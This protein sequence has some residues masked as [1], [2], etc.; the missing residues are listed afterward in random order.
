MAEVIK[1]GFIVDPEILALV[2]KDPVAAMSLDSDAFVELITRAI[3][4]KADVVSS[5]PTEQGRAEI[6]NYGHTF[7]HAIQTGAGSR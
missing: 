7:A 6:R 3:H 5:D 2:E 4:M 1:A